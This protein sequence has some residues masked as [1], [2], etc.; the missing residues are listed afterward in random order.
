MPVG[1]CNFFLRL[2][3]RPPRGCKY[4]YWHLSFCFT[5]LLNFAPLGKAVAAVKHDNNGNRVV[6]P[7]ERLA[8]NSLLQPHNTENIHFGS[9]RWTWRG[10]L[11]V[12]AFPRAF[13]LHFESGPYAGPCISDRPCSAQVRT[14][15]CQ[16][17][18]QVNLLANGSFCT[19]T[20]AAKR[21]SHLICAW[22]RHSD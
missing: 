4:R 2:C 3:W 5:F 6:I 8:T 7:L 10:H 15:G 17:I 19:S 22:G 14:P 1:N 11:W 13:S 21:R 18:H 16:I 12:P 20:S 9:A